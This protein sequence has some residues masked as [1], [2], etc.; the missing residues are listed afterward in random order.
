MRILLT[1]GTGLIGRAL[2][3]HWQRQ[4]HE[5]MGLEPRPSSKYRPVQRRTGASRN[6]KRFDG[7]APLDAVG[8]ISQARRLPTALIRPGRRDLLWRS[9]GGSDA[10]LVDWMGR[11]P[12]PPRAC[13]C[14]AWPSAGMATAASNG[15]PKT[16]AGQRRLRQP[17][18]RGLGRQIIAERARQWGWVRGV[19]CALRPVLAPR[20]AMLHGCCRLSGWPMAGA[21]VAASSDA[22]D[23]SETTRW[24]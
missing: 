10:H 21:W 19:Y 11:A 17:P 13:C 2:C 24:L 4:G 14:Q 3:Q 1:G 12:S 20:G 16:R 15:W 7:S 8:S 9:R 23:P 22:L 5:L 18:V 6:C